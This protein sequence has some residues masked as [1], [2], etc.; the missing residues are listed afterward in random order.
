MRLVVVDFF[1]ELLDELQISF[2]QAVK[3]REDED[4]LV[5]GDVQQ[6]EAGCPWSSL[7][8]V[9][10]INL[11]FK[12]DEVCAMYPDF[13]PV[14]HSD[15]GCSVVD[16]WNILMA[17]KGSQRPRKYAVFAVCARASGPLL[18]RQYNRRD[19]V[20][21]TMVNDSGLLTTVNYSPL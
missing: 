1:S 9:D 3:V 14:V 7:L 6:R 5:G 19:N 11:F 13:C 10:M 4:I 16:K 17:N 15:F 12:G 21:V 18:G 2:T 8:G 20:Y